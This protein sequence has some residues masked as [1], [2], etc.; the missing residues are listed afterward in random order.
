[1]RDPTTGGLPASLSFSAVCTVLHAT[2]PGPEDGG[3]HWQAGSEGERKGEGRTRQKA[4]D[5]AL[6]ALLK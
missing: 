5:F 6:S 3:G 4:A 1:M 2:G